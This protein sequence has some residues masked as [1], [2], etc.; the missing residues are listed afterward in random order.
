MRTTVT[1]DPDVEKRLREVMRANKL[2]FKSALN[3]TIRRGIDSLLPNS[4]GKP[5]RTKTE[6]MGVHTHLNYD[7][8][9]ELLE[10]AEKSSPHASLTR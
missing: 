9:G 7:N 2:S 5:F 6:K 10:I 1:I 8:I 3:E 4:K